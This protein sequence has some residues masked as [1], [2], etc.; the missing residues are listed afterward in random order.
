MKKLLAAM[1]IMICLLSSAAAEEAPFDFK[2]FRWG[3]AKE[4]IIAV[5]GQPKQKITDSQYQAEVLCYQT[6]VVGLTAELMYMFSDTEGL[7]TVVYTLQEKEDS[8]EAYI[9][10]YEL[11]KTALTGKYGAPVF[12]EETWNCGDVLKAVYE[13]DLD[14]AFRLGYL[15]FDTVY[16]TDTTTIWLSMVG[17]MFD[18]TT[19]IV[20]SSHTI[21]PVLRDFSNEI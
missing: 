1:M 9:S 7:F 8:A 13:D 19:D 5:E 16:E 21:K 11:L 4:Q 17:D 20:Y 14:T 6:T 2:Q 18:A 15:T 12:D 10:N 3:D